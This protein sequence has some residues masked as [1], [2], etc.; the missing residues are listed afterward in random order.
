MADMIA[1]QMLVPEAAEIRAQL[2]RILASKLFASSFSLGR[3]FRFIV[4]ETMAGRAGSLK[5]Y[6]IGVQVFDRGADFDPRIDPIVRVQARN[7]RLKLERFYAA[8]GTGG[9]VHI[10]LPKGSYVPLFEPLGLPLNEAEEPSLAPPE[11][12]PMAARRI[13]PLWLPAAA[14]CLAVLSLGALFVRG[15]RRPA[16]AARPAP[17]SEAQSLYTRGRYLLDRQQQPDAL[18]KSAATFRKAIQ[19]EPNFAAAWAG[20]ADSYDLMA[21]FGILP[22]GDAMAEA[23]RAAQRALD[24][25]P[26]LAEAHISMAAIF[27]A[28]DWNWK[29]A[30]REYRRALELN[31]ALAA[32]HMWYGMFL[33]DQGRLKEAVPELER[34]SRIDPLSLLAVV[35]LA[36]AYVLKG[37]QGAAARVAAIG[38]DLEP[39]SLEPRLIASRLASK[40]HTAEIAALE[41]ALA[42]TPEDPS[43]LGMLAKL[44]AGADRQADAGRLLDALRHMAQRQYVSPFGIAR[45]YLALDD[46][47]GALPYLEAAYRERSSGIVFL[48]QSRYASQP[49]FR[50]IIARLHS[51]T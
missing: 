23:R 17:E 22:P 36:H 49:K 42:A 32:A 33:R 28:Y 11:P 9:A 41:Q 31:P 3:F 43:T 4:E 46:P 48:W 15:D 34:A 20:L 16:V 19:L 30:E 25:D 8:N 12:Q 7:L 40:D 51:N 29:G 38:L 5:E 14:A 50:E 2:E 6:T 37:D 21:Q 39:R 24:L 13:V 44:Y 18:R 27:E 1:S 10:A 45:V 47:D 26:S 35:N